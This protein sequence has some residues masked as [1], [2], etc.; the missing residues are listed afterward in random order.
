MRGCVFVEEVFTFAV[1]CVFVLLEWIVVIDE[2]DAV[3]GQ[4]DN[5][6]E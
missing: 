4:A 6:S 3:H 5:G 1:D 2:Y